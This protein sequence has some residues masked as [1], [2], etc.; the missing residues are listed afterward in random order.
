[1]VGKPTIWAEVDEEGRL[2]LPAE[3]AQRYGLQPGAQVR[4]DEENG[5]IRVHRPVS[6]LNKIYVEPSLRCNLACRTCVRNTWA[7]DGGDMSEE[8]F[9]A[10]LDDVSRLLATPDVFFGGLGEPLIHRQIAAWIRALKE[11][12]ASVEL[13]TN[14]TMLTERRGRQLIDAGLDVIWVS[15]DGATP[16]SYADVRL[17]AELPRIVENVRHFRKI[18]PGGHHPRPE[19]GVVFVAMR[20]NVHEL[21][22]VLHLARSLGAKRFMVSNVLPYSEEMLEETLYDDT[23]RSVTYMSSPW[24]AKL[25]LPRMDFDERTHDALL[26]A[27][28][29]DYNVTFAGNS[30][31]GASD[32]C[33]FIQSGTIS[34]GWD[35][36]VAPCLPLLHTHVS[37]LHGKERINRRHVLGNVRE[38][39]LMKIWRDPEYVAYRQRVQSFAFA[40]CTFCGGCEL[41][42]ANEEDCLGN[43]FPSCGG[44]LWA[45]GVIHCP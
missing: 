4:L 29:S 20:R 28:D 9:A 17:G 38:Q 21:P 1:M 2:I 25:K 31:G 35:G 42:E 32:V 45:Q 24:H 19:I 10:I 27:F 30:L 7:E 40:P 22:N 12:G 43:G 44:C 15:I 26:R 39:G 5:N 37:Y 14:G 36:R 33:T 3:V 8:T 6:H 18:R 11:V 16:E 13:I 34:I 41:S 23:L